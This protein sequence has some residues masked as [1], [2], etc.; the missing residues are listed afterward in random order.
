MP[1]L[2]VGEDK[3]MERNEEFLKVIKNSKNESDRGI[4]LIVAA[5]IED[6]LRRILES[7]LINEKESQDL[8]DGPYA[9]FGSLSGKTQAAF[10]LGLIT[11]K[12]RD[13]VDAVRRV[14]NVFAHEASASFDHPE[15]VKI[16]NK[17]VV[18]GGRMIL[19]DEFLHMAL[20]VVPPLLYRDLQIVSWRRP[21]LTQDVI[22]EWHSG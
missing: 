8:F 19:R 12:E 14:R 3:V 6:C 20:N 1:R 10:V 18:N 21:E 11:R 15:I 2:A 17:P 16:C 4:T 9:P 13:R 7:I 22:N 5:Y